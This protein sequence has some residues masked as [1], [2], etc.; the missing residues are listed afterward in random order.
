M[1][2]YRPQ[3]RNVLALLASMDLPADPDGLGV[4]FTTERKKTKPRGA[5][6]LLQGFDR[7]ENAGTPDMTDHFAS[8]TEEYLNRSGKRNTLS[9]IIHPKSTPKSGLRRLTPLR[10]YPRRLATFYN[11]GHRIRDFDR[12]YLGTQAHQ[13]ARWDPIHRICQQRRRDQTA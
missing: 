4:Y 8:I 13:Q 1:R 9:Q 10:S 5:Q 11:L 12:L 2:P 6:L 3:L 7:R